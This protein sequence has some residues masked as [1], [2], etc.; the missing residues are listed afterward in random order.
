MPLGDPPAEVC[1]E[2]RAPIDDAVDPPA[3]L[4]DERAI[5]P[6]HATATLKLR[7]HGEVDRS[8]KAMLERAVP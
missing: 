7:A 4:S 5:E 8:L 2:E 1:Q 6:P 3:L